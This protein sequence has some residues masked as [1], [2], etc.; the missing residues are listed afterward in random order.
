MNKRNE[1]GKWRRIE[2]RKVRMEREK[3]KEKAEENIENSMNIS[4]RTER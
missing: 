1:K 4:R 2:E 3:K